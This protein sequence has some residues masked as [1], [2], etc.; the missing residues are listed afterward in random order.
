MGRVNIIQQQPRWA[1]E[2]PPAGSGERLVEG[3]DAGKSNDELTDGRLARKLTLQDKR[4]SLTPWMFEC[5]VFL[6]ANKELWGMADT[7]VAAKMAEGENIDPREA[8]DYEANKELLDGL[9]AADDM[10]EVE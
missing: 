4:A 6:Q 5:I 10:E 1:V 3:D 9:E 2:P 7:V 8:A